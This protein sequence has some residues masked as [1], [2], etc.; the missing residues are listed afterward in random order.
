M[1]DNE[2]NR[3]YNV[4]GLKFKLNYKNEYHLVG[5]NKL[6]PMNKILKEYIDNG[7]D[8]KLEDDIKTLVDIDG[9]HI[10]SLDMV[11]RYDSDWSGYIYNHAIIN[12]NKK[13]HW[14]M[15][16]NLIHTYKNMVTIAVI[17]SRRVI[18][19]KEHSAML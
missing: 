6:S 19:R 10:N 1:Y 2:K 11:C 9:F 17:P 7:L 3:N 5:I 16:L 14:E 15:G 4:S 8:D 13:D 18:T 12:E